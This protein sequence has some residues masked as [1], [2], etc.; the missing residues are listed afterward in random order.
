MTQSSPTD[1]LGMARLAETI[2]RGLGWIL[3]P[4]QVRRLAVAQAD[5]EVIRERGHQTALTIAERAS[6][7]RAFELRREQQNLEGI[8]HSTVEL[9]AETTEFSEEP[10]EADWAAEFFGHAK[11]VSDERARV[12]WA[13]LLAAEV[14]RPGSCSRRTLGVLSQLSKA[15]A[16]LF[17][18]F[19][20]CVWEIDGQA[21]APFIQSNG[22]RTAAEPTRRLHDAGLL[23]FGQHHGRQDVLLS[24]QADFPLSYCG[25]RYMGGKKVGVAEPRLI[26]FR[27][28]SA[29]HQLLSVCQPN[30]DPGIESECLKSF[31]QIGVVVR[32]QA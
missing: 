14:R 22:G 5:A 13:R 20:A 31:D 26:A 27:L 30:P 2:G 16:E 11:M 10:V 32:P 17:T 7:R 28:T 23:F 25:N 12:L 6:I 1:L 8:I 29:G 4:R 15:E 19:A 3:E 9:L 21:L 18:W 24:S